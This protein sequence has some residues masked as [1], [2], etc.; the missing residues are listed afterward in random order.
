M[1]KQVATKIWASIPDRLA[2]KLDKR[3][4][5]EGRSRSDLISYLLERSMESWHPSVELKEG[6][7]GN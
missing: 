4:E 6:K 3:A 5:S 1:G 2:E 7:N